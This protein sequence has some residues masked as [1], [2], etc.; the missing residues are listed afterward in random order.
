MIR[1]E[2][3]SFK[4]LGRARCA[5]GESPIWDATEEVLYWVDI[6][7]KRLHA[8]ELRTGQ[9]RHWAQPEI[10][11]AA[12]MRRSGGLI[13]VLERRVAFFDPRSETLE[14]LCTIED[15]AGNRANDSRVDAGGHLWIGTMQNNIAPDGQALPVT[16]SSGGLYRVDLAGRVT[17][18]HA[19]L[20]IPN[21]IAWSP[22]NHTMYVADTLE[23][24]MFSFNFDVERGSLTE[25]RDF[26]DTAPGFADGSCVDHDG[27]IWN[28]RWGGSCLARFS[29]DGRLERLVELP[30]TNPT[31]CTFDGSGNHILYVTSATHGLDANALAVNPLEGAVLALDIGVSGPAAW[32]FGG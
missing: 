17:C 2:H 4:V 25:R 19:K 18:A 1:K 29:P 15:V 3:V 9:E 26:Q 14:I 30:V 6:P 13:L 7:A 27:F 20:G 8:F 11:A 10:V 12:S 23:N 16:R 28:A 22:D 31:S 5:V 21:S 32:A 24:T